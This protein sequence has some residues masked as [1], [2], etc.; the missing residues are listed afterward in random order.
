LGL[1]FALPLVY[2]SAK[3][4]ASRVFGLVAPDG[5]MLAEVFVSF[6][7]VSAAAALLPA[8]KATRVDPAEALRLP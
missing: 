7:L 4:L 1:A 5:G 8:V 3:L 6:L 2:L